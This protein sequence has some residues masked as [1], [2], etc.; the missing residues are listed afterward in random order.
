MQSN[1]T[2][3]GGLPIVWDCV[4]HPDQEWKLEDAGNGFVKIRNKNWGK[5]LNLQ[6]NATQNGGLPIVWDCVSHPDQEWKLEAV[7]DSPSSSDKLP[8][9]T[10]GTVKSTNN[11]KSMGGGYAESEGTF[12]RN[13]L[14]VI[15]THS[16]SSSLTQGTKGSVF[17]VGSDSKGRALFAS[18]VFN[19][20]TA[21]SKTDTCSS[22]RRDTI[23]H[24]VNSELAKY[25]AKIDVYVQ[26]RGTPSLR[27]SINTTIT[28]TCGTYDDLPP[29][30]KAG[31]AY[32]TGFAGCGPR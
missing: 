30:A 23:Q 10:S 25:V 20:P 2:Q 26:D 9:E 22:N 32:E 3:N 14:T 12:Y 24:Q 6:S 21:C 1:A 5:C 11:R 27:Q 18:P 15:E 28:Q 7:E 8:Q 13:G 19:I 17:V 4:S 16:V 29:A 31:I